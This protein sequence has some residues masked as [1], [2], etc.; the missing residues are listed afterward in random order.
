MKFFLQY[1]TG[2]RVVPKKYFDVLNTSNRGGL[3]VPVLRYA[4]I[5]LM[6][7]E[8]LNEEA[9]IGADDSPAFQN[10][11]T[12]RERAGLAPYTTV[13]LVNQVTFRAAVL[14]ER[15]LELALE[16]H[17]WYDLKRTNT[18]ISTF[19]ALGVTVQECNLIYPIPQIVIERA[20][21]PVGFPQNPTCN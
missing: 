21:D 14:N 12:V 16:F 11:N 6:Y 4:D 1:V 7:A 20:A 2:S 8:V 17:R 10:L 9:Y 3:D 19:A 15:R 5:L 13:D 18:V